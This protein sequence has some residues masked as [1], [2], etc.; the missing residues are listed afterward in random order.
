M[1]PSIVVVTLTIFYNSIFPFVPYIGDD[2][3]LLHN[4]PKFTVLGEYFEDID[5]HVM[6]W[7]TKRRDLNPIEHL[8]YEIMLIMLQSVVEIWNE[9]S[10][11]IL[12]HIIHN[13]TPRKLV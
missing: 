3:A 7:P 1:V 8:C 9:A 12:N 5:V 13:V 4:N 11:S 10:Q 6:N 2:F